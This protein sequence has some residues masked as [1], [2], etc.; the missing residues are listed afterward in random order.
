MFSRFMN[1][2]LTDE[3]TSQ[4]SS[5][6]A[7]LGIAAAA[8][9]AAVIVGWYTHSA[10]LVQLRPSFAPM[11]YNTAL[12]FV[13]LG[14]GL[15]AASGLRDRIGGV[16][17]AITA[18]IGLLTLAEYKPGLPVSLDQLLFKAYIDTN[19]SNP[20]RMSPVTALCFALTGVAL[21]LVCLRKPKRYSTA[22]ALLTSV[23]V[24]LSALTMFGYA[25]NL[26]GATGWYLFTRVALHTAAGFSAV[27]LGVFALA[28]RASTSQSCGARRW[29]PVSV[30]LAAM[31][32]SLGL[33]QALVVNER[34]EMERTIRAEASALRNEIAARLD[35][36]AHSLE[37]LVRRWELAGE[38]LG[39][40]P[41][42]ELNVHLEGYAD[43]QS[44]VR[45]D[46]RPAIGDGL[47]PVITR[48]IE[49]AQGERGLPLYVPIRT[50]TKLSGYVVEVIRLRQFLDAKLPAGSAEGYSINVLENGKT[51]Y[52]RALSLPPREK[53]WIVESPINAHGAPWTVRI[54][55]G[56]EMLKQR[57]APLPTAILIAG[58]LGSALL[59]L[60]VFLAQKGSARAK[61]TIA[62]NDALH[63]E[64]AERNRAEEAEQRFAAILEA[65]TDFVAIATPAGNVLYVNRAGRR[66]AGIAD[67]ADVTRSTF[68]D[69][70]TETAAAVLLRDAV[71][72]A[73]RDGAWSGETTLLSGDGQ[74]IP[75]SE[76]IISH[77]GSDGKLKFLST[78][79][80]DI[81]EVRERERR[82]RESEENFRQMA[83]NI[84]DVFYIQ[85]SDMQTVH[86]LSPAYESIWGRPVAAVY[87]D[88]YEWARSI[89][90][91]ERERVYTTFAALADRDG[92]PT[93]SAEF[94]IVRPDGEIR[95][96]LSRGFQV[97]DESGNVIRITGVATDITERKAMLEEL[98]HARK[99]LERIVE[100]RSR[101]LN[102]VKAALDEHAIVAFTDARGK[103]LF[104]ND[105]FCAISQYSREELLGQDHRLVNSGHH[106]KEFF[107]NLW[108]TISSGRVWKGEV[109]NRAKDGSYYWVDTTLVPFLDASGK[110]YQYVAIR[111][112]ITERKR[113]EEALIERTMKLQESEQ[114][115]RFLA[116]TMPQII[117][118]A[119]PDGNLDYYN[120][121]WYSYTGMT[122]EQTRV[123]SW[124]PVLH[125]DDLQNCL[126]TWERSI[127]TGCDY[128]VEYRFRRA[129]DN[130]YRW[131]LG[132]SFPLRDEEGRIVQWVGTCTDID[133]QKCA[134]EALRHAHAELEV[135]VMER[136]AEL[137]TAKAKL[138]AV[139]DAATH[140]S[141]IATDPQGTITLFNAGAERMLGYRADETIGH[142]TPAI[143]HDISEMT[144]RARELSEELGT[145]IEPGFETFVTT[146][147]H[148]TPD[149]REWTYVRKDG[150]RFPVLLSVT[151]LAGENGRIEGFLGVAA[152]MTEPKRTE[153]E[154]VRAKEAAEAATR[155]KSGFLAVMSHEIRTPMNGV[156]GMTQ[157]L[158][159]TEL[160]QKQ[161]HFA[162]TIQTS[163]DSLLTVIND[164]LDFSKIEAGKL[165]FE[166]LDF[167]LRQAVES[168]LDL[169]SERAHAKGIELIGH[170]GPDVQTNLRGDSTRLRQVLNNLVSNAVKFTEKGEVVVRVIKESETD[171]DI[172]L[173][174]E[175]EDT[176][177]GISL[178]AQERLFQAFQQADGSTTRRYGGTGLGLAIARQLVG[179]MHGEIAVDSEPDHGST[180]HFSVCLK[181]QLPSAAAAQRRP[182][183]PARGRVLIIDDNATNLEI[184]SR[185]IE[186][187]KIRGTSIGNGRE[188][189]ELLH[190]AA[191]SNDPFNLVILDMQMPGMDGIELAGAIRSDG[192]LGDIRLIMLTSL[193]HQPD[194]ET[195]RKNGIAACLSKPVRQSLLFDCIATTLAG[196]TPSV[197]RPANLLSADPSRTDRARSVRILVAE[198]NE[199]NQM[200]ALEQLRKLGHKADL[201]SNGREA[202]M[203]LEQNT[204]DVV[205]MD[206][207]MPELDGYETSSRI[208][209]LEQER[210]AGLGSLRPLH[211]VAMTANAMKGDREKCLAAGMND[212]LSKPVSSSEMKRALDQW[213]EV[214][215]DPETSPDPRG[216]ADCLIDLERLLD[217]TSSDDDQL[218]DLVS[219]YLEQA[220][221][222]LV[223]LDLAIQ[224][225]AA[226]DVRHLAHKLAGSSST[227]G[228]T[229]VV[230]PLMRLEQMGKSGELGEAAGLHAETSRQLERLRRYLDGYLKTNCVLSEGVPA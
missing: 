18:A 109:K 78:I 212:Y 60:T 223:S 44:I 167:D 185:A 152:D 68:S 131:H 61:E 58:L 162:E 215:S 36:R 117:W 183:D 12:C 155:A 105:K 197:I 132:R 49:L 178:E 3:E 34:A 203:A 158:L 199:I 124:Q 107:R 76:V 39:K 170:I 111:A 82:L 209:Q 164:I 19:T 115:Y 145:P 48:T 100:E 149:E 147:R 116:E 230:A 179:L 102:Y 112:D 122:F 77:Q 27:G 127:R 206:C 92:E 141:I 53:A 128:E 134:E 55:P 133:D 62:A 99:E 187:W 83:E 51:I 157:L 10:A 201:V 46:P 14:I 97:R 54:W 136:T 29:L 218:R 63:L 35:S 37:R 217:V 57:G 4:T 144:R 42:H 2:V 208:R 22:A 175:V 21:V 228:M 150:S 38:D 1:R 119:K 5:L 138:Q 195:L 130:T 96:I 120:E 91:E 140:S 32:L 15:A 204:Y 52:A 87:A 188:A 59:G 11:K 79:M 129:S 73:L 47:H 211:I 193:G 56:P 224:H 186:A 168:T 106:P 26:S 137:G 139:M 66:M 118:T 13:L 86:Y 196:E 93:A 41:D 174:F 89:V 216:D 30:G 220:G 213:F 225:G 189:L 121:R 71:P 69:Y 20:G 114:R 148:G 24:A 190:A 70:Y 45:I 104:V 125:P 108:Q 161:R 95:W 192:Q 103:I 65:T 80:R 8:V 176:G 198:D 194:Q 25:T 153:Q 221:H 74:E 163:A 64:M 191:A 31:T 227:C 72:V 85:S 110:P 6:A 84:G 75:V 90:P 205:F 182:F 165:T 229:A 154:L 173:R 169:M 101:E 67:D 219:R 135:R 98:L 172:N 214:T 28:W 146:A 126:E 43:I 94:R 207:M 166:T 180:F 23:T 7:A 160:D 9:G 159:D 40:I 50:A 156:I 177:I 210:V 17:G 200:V 113:A 33:W 202:L 142:L 181:K 16:L 222:A 143:F 184:L 123:N 226:E 171:A 81:S 88:P 151:A